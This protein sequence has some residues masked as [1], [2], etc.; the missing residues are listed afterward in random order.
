MKNTNLE[1]VKTPKFSQARTFQVLKS[2][3]KISD[4]KMLENFDPFED[5][6]TTITNSNK[7]ILT[8]RFNY[9]IKHKRK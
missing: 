1:R 7:H 4:F 2:E 6:E 9:K 3:S 5:F 8:E